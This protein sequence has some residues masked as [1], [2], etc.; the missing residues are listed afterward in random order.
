MRR[1]F[2]N[3]FSVVTL[4]SGLSAACELGS[5]PIYPSSSQESSNNGVGFSDEYADFREDYLCPSRSNVVPYPERTI[6]GDREFKVCVQRTEDA[7]IAIEYGTAIDAPMICVFP[8][9]YD[10]D[11]STITA[12]KD[13]TTRK[14]LSV[15]VQATSDTGYST[16][17]QYEYSMIPI[18]FPTDQFN[19]VFIVN[20][21]NA[22]AMQTCLDRDQVSA[23]ACPAFSLGILK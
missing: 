14:V 21:K 23:S 20:S 11:T 5:Y 7:N 2:L 1:S 6:E 9:Q 12:L 19:G 3:L 13:S 10:R 18:E 8:F 17:N 16:L 4:L 15:C 22:V